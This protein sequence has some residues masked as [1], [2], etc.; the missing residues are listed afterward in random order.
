MT[1]GVQWG[2]HQPQSPN[3]VDNWPIFT[4]KSLNLKNVSSENYY[5]DCIAIAETFLNLAKRI[6]AFIFMTRC[7]YWLCKAKN[8]HNSLWSDE[9]SHWANITGVTAAGKPG[10]STEVAEAQIT[11]AN[12]V[13]TI[14]ETST[15]CRLDQMNLSCSWIPLPTSNFAFTK[16]TTSDRNFLH[17][18]DTRK[19]LDHNKRQYSKTLPSDMKTNYHSILFT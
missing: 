6:M 13:C 10:W 19:E 11:I 8:K 9:I 18:R 17:R 2:N 16:G 3:F 15:S 1:S 5:A 14:R 4:I 7:S 12:Y